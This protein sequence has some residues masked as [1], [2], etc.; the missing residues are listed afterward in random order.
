MNCFPSFYT[1]VFK[2]LIAS[3]IQRKEIV[4]DYWANY[5]ANTS[6]SDLDSDIDSDISSDIDITSSEEIHLPLSNSESNSDFDSD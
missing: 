3:Q 1:Y 4:Y 5:W 6:D 2:C